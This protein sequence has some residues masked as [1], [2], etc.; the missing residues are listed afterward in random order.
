MYSL[1]TAA[2]AKGGGGYFGGGNKQ[3][4][5]NT[6]GG[7]K[8]CYGGSNYGGT[9]EFKTIGGNVST[10]TWGSRGGSGVFFI[11]FDKCP[12]TQ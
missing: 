11:V 3:G 9:C 10:E 4:K 7:G 6:G 12:C 5:P 1:S 2:G 8:G